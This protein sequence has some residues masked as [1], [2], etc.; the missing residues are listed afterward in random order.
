MADSPN[1]TQVNRVLVKLRASTPLAAAVANA[2]LRPVFDRPFTSGG[3]GADSAPQWFIAD[4]PDL[5]VSPRRQANPWDFAHARLADQL[6]VDED[7]LMFAEPDRVHDQAFHLDSEG[8]RTCAAIPQ[9]G[10]H[11]KAVGPEELAWHL[12]EKFSQ[13]AAAREAV[14]F[15][16]PRVR[17]GHLDTGYDLDHDTLPKHLLRELGRSFVE[18]DRFHNSAVDPNNEV[19]LLDNSGHGT[20]TLGILAGGPTGATPEVALGGAQEAEVLPVRISDR[21]VLLRTSALAAGLQYAADSRC[22]VITLSMGGLPSR[23]WGEVIDELYERGVCICAAAGNHVGSSPPRVLVYPARYPRVI[24]VC[25]VMADGRPYAD[26]DGVLEGS[27]GPASVMGQAIAAYTPNIPWPQYGCRGGVR[28]NGE[29]TSAATPQVAAAAALWLECH[30]QRLPRDWRRVEAVRHALFSTARAGDAKHFGNG[31]LQAHSALGVTPDLNR[32]RSP[33][34]KASFSLFRLITGLGLAEVPVREQM[35]NLELE[36]RL[37]LNARLQSIVRDPDRKRPLTDQQLRELMTAIIEDEEASDALR[38]H[39]AMRYPAVTGRSAPTS[40]K[41]KGIVAEVVRA[42]DAVPQLHDPVYRR[43][44]VYAVDPS[45][46]TRLDT[47]GIDETTLQVRWE[48]LKPESEPPVGNQPS[49]AESGRPAR[50]APGPMGEYFEIDDADAADEFYGMVDLDDPRLLAQDGWAPSEGNPH[51]HQQMVYAVAMSTVQQFERALGRP[52]FWRPMPN[53]AFRR[54]LTLRPHALRQANAFYSPEEVALLFGYFD[55]DTDDPGKDMPGGRIYSCLSH[56]I[57]AHET[58]HAILDGMQRY[59]NQPTNPDVLAFHE[60]FADLVA[61]L[62][63]F[64]LTDVLEHE[65]IRT[66]GDLETES[67]IGSL[68]IQF[69]RAS[70]NRAALRDAIGRIE[71]GIWHRSQPNP[72]QYDTATT[73]HAR[74]AVLVAAIFDAFLAI[75][76]TRTSDLLRL[77]S[78]GSGNLPP[79]AIHPDLVHRLC[80]EASKS[81]KHV[82]T[83]IIRALD[84]LPPVDVTFFEFLRA[85]ITADFDLVPDDRLNY[86]VAFIDAFRRRGIYPKD[87]S[88]QTTAAGRTLSVETLRWHPPDRARRP[89]QW[90]AIESNYNKIV[91]SL[92]PYADKSHYLK[93]RGERFT[94]KIHRQKALKEQAIDTFRSAPDFA[95]EVGLNPDHPFEIEELRNAMRIGP[96][97]QNI[98]QVLISLIQTVPVRT[99]AQSYE[100]TGGSTLIIDLTIPAVRYCV[101]KSVDNAATRNRTAEFLAEAQ[102][103][104]LHALFFRPD[105]RRPFAALHQLSSAL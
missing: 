99:D 91:E 87:G 4:V 83:M 102:G 82:L 19:F 34:S 77:S 21:V 92:K 67:V 9:D 94:K 24:A 46:S 57:I 105:P 98:P 47:A 55:A 75:Y 7:D 95:R 48:S 84:Y 1:G 3:L 23:L 54:R 28:L 43:L 29:G 16:E 70:G 8:I 63:H 25:G 104:P 35:F 30:K 62:Q 76:N 97:G 71:D 18:A 50:R 86:R 89:K 64:A 93:D 73:P 68:A 81:A 14:R 20:G 33:T 15:T 12:G 27:F 59:Y 17:I 85:L 13:L 90:D 31:I 100:F 41:T 11:G 78:G 49:S 74:G 5:A 58:T 53:G 61:L 66:R 6:G 101:S 26:L 103:D 60:A 10:G 80:D 96:D 45:F 65:I 44:R 51:F 32:S 39:V 52:V 88:N 38:R 36:Q 56:D 2:N 69:G 72:A 40:P 37:L 22:D 79:G 42:C